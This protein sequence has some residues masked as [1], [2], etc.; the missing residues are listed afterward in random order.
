MTYYNTALVSEFFPWISSLSSKYRT[1]HLGTEAVTH[2]ANLL[3]AQSLPDILDRRLND[4]INI[5]GLVLGQPRTQIDLARLHVR[6]ADLVTLEQV[7]DD[8]QVAAL[9]ELIGE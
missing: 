5:A 4:G 9:G 3:H 7:R 6:D 2:S 1:T 8:R